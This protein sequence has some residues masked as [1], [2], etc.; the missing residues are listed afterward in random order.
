MLLGAALPFVVGALLYAR[1]GFRASTRLLVWVP[2]IMGLL[3]VWAIVPDIPRA[4]G[5]DELYQA[6]RHS[7]LSDVFF[8]HHTIDR[9]ESDSPI[10]AVG[11]VLMGVSVLLAGWR[12]LA[13]REAEVR[14]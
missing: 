13:L 12:E 4:L 8:F 7:E 6:M 5:A 1:A 2:L 11:F 10:Y 14:R 9:V 3:G